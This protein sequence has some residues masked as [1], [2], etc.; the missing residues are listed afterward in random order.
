[1]SVYHLK[2]KDWKQEDRPREKL[3]DKGRE[4]LSDPEL[5][6]ILLGSGTQHVT[7]VELARK[8]LFKYENSFIN[9]SRAS[10]EELCTIPGIGRAKATV[11]H[12]LVELARR[13]KFFSSSKRPIIRSAKEAYNFIRGDFLGKMLEEFWVVLLNGANRVMKKILVSKGGIKSTSADPKVVLKKVLENQAVGFFVAHNH[14][15]GIA[16]PSKADLLITKSLSEASKSLGLFFLDHLIV[17]DKSFF[18]INQLGM[19]Y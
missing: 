6:A 9:L 2:I 12:S 8:V 10:I 11:I 7:A 17:T 19:I 15:S 13:Q 1:M 5:L 16:Y 3:I 14:P 18:S 4:G